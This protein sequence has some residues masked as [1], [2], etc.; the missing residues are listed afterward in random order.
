M[1][2]IPPME[3]NMGIQAGFPAETLKEMFKAVPFD[4]SQFRVGETPL[5]NE[6][7]PPAAVK[8]YR[9]KGF[10]HG[11]NGMCKSPYATT[12]AN[13]FFDCLSE[14]QSDILHSMVRIYPKIT[15]CLAFEI[16]P[17]MACHSLKHVIQERNAGLCQAN[18]GTIQI[19]H[20]SDPGLFCT[21]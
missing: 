2:V 11:N 17:A 1:V 10:I 3:Y 20:Q 5:E 9:G 16:E 19:Q 21:A 13:R 8:G 14:D 6:E 4:S 15:G 12:I 7:S 18:P